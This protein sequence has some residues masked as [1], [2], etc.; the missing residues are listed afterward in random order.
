MNKN[1]FVP[2]VLVWADL[3]ELDPRWMGAWW[4]GFPI[5]AT[6]LFTFSG[7]FQTNFQMVF[8]KDATKTPSIFVYRT[9]DISTLSHSLDRAGIYLSCLVQKYKWR[10][11]INTSPVKS[12]FCTNEQLTGARNYTRIMS[13]LRQILLNNYL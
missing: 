4:I 5:L 13:S 2:T 12:C 10:F 7:I 1:Y 8:L 3:T 11:A 9:A 6:L